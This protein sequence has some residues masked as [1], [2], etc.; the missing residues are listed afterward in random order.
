MTEHPR[1]KAR[2]LILALVALALLLNSALAQ[3]DNRTAVIALT[4]DASF[5]AVDPRI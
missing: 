5:L 2:T 1:A 3:S 4:G